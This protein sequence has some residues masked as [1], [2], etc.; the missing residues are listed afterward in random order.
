MKAVY[1]I[2]VNDRHRLTTEQVLNQHCWYSVAN[3]FMMWWWVVNCYYQSSIVR[4]FNEVLSSGVFGFYFY[5]IAIS[6]VIIFRHL[7]LKYGNQSLSPC[8]L[9]SR[10]YTRNHET[11]KFDVL[12]YLFI[13]LL[14]RAPASYWNVFQSIRNN[15]ILES[16][17]FAVVVCCWR[18]HWQLLWLHISRQPLGIM[19]KCLHLQSVL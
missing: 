9:K 13:Y 7:R 3:T 15:K 12:F 16:R 2:E 5:W 8:K 18:L 6:I 17:W 10:Y 4:V 19:W 14:N 1:R 11:H